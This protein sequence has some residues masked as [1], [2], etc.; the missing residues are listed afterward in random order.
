[1]SIVCYKCTPETQ[2]DDV[3]VGCSEHGTDALLHD[4]TTGGGESVIR[5]VRPND[6]VGTAYGGERVR[7]DASELHHPS[8]VAALWTL[9]EAEEAAQEVERRRASMFRH[10]PTAAQRAT[11]RQLTEA[12]R[13]RAADREK[14][15]SEADTAALIER[16]RRADDEERPRTGRK[17]SS[18]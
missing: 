17:S 3:T 1:M 9:E 5:I 14:Q 6:H 13:Q 2:V 7:L 8:L 10:E 18:K 12:I 4:L 11:D 16:Q 15:R